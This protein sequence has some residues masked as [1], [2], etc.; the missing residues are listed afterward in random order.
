[1]KLKATVLFLAIFVSSNVY[2][3]SNVIQVKPKG[4]VHKW[5]FY[6]NTGSWVIEPRFNSARDF[7]NGYAAVSNEY[8]W[9]LI[10]KKG[11]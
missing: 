2:S 6:D 10:D 1:M 4:K 8:G 5:G 11:F 7:K 9:G 3:Q